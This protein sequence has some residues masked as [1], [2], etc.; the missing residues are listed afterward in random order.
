LRVRFLPP[1]LRVKRPVQVASA[2][3]RTFSGAATP[4]I[5]GTLKKVDF[6]IQSPPLPTFLSPRSRS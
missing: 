5:G 6:A 1:R 2:S 4:S 3:S